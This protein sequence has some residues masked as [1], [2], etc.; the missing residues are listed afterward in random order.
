MKSI[1]L[2]ERRGEALGQNGDRDLCRITKMRTVLQPINKGRGSPHKR[3]EKR[4]LTFTL[5]TV[6]LQEEDE[7]KGDRA[8]SAAS[9]SH[10]SSDNPLHCPFLLVLK[11]AFNPRLSPRH[12]TLLLFWCFN[13]NSFYHIFVLFLP[14]CLCSILNDLLSTLFQLWSRTL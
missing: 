11:P 8:F 6:Y 5:P 2:R 7:H 4:V 14:F 9:T 13:C 12:E 1:N 3:K 10:Y